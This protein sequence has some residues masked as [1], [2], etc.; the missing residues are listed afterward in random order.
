MGHWGAAQRLQPAGKVLPNGADG[1][2]ASLALWGILSYKI[3]VLVNQYVVNLQ[4]PGVVYA[5]DV[6][7]Q[8]DKS[9]K[10]RICNLQLFQRTH[11]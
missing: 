3:M 7:E 9:C 11:E 8:L 10:H 1:P 2:S 4:H 5:I 6:Y